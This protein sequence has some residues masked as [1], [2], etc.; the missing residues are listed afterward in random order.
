[1]CPS[2]YTGHGN[3]MGKAVFVLTLFLAA[4]SC[5]DKSASELTVEQMNVI[6]TG[7]GMLARN[8][9]YMPDSTGWSE[10]PGQEL[11]DEIENLAQS[12]TEV[13]PVF[14][15]AAADTASKLDQLE[16]QSRLEAAQADLL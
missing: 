8:L 1:M 7:A 3:T 15:R 12:H 14:F 2:H 4:A 6:T 5:S 10:P 16:Q 9:S 13:W 11:L